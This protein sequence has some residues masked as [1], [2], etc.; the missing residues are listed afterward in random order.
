MFATS[1]P[2]QAPIHVTSAPPVD[3]FHDWLYQPEWRLSPRASKA[4]DFV[5]PPK[6]IAERALPLLNRLGEEQDITHY[7]SL[8]PE[9]ER[10]SAEF[11]VRAFHQ[12]GWPA[13]TSPNGDRD[14]VPERLGVV[15]QH[16]RLFVRLLEIM[17]D[18]GWRLPQQTDLEV[19]WNDLLRQY[20]RAN[21]EL[22][23][24]KRCGENLA[25]VLRDEH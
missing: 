23:L 4:A 9:L 17:D 7:G 2:S 6:Q 21:A 8:L 16:R 18:E 1:E 13:G 12:L 22:T 10:L 3:R 24:L 5:I 14:T 25:K 20:P 11:V 19:R 15:S